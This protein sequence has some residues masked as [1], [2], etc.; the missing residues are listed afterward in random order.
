MTAC[1][2]YRHKGVR[3]RQT[4]LAAAERWRAAQ[5]AGGNDEYD[6]PLASEMQP[7]SAYINE[8]RW[9][10]DCPCGNGAP[11]LPQESAAV[12]FSCGSVHTNVS[13]PADADAIERVLLRRKFRRNQNWFQSET[14]EQLQEENERHRDQLRGEG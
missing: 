11:V 2:V 9:L 8:G 6:A 4:L 1:D 14:V 5:V 10:V 7:I 3:D 13:M 12:C